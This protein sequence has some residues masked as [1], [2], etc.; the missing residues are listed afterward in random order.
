MV[1]S[2]PQA[3]SFE[4]FVDQYG[5]DTR[6][7]LI[8]GELIDME[9]TG[10]HVREAAPPEQQVSGFIN[11]QLN[12]EIA[13]LRQPY[14]IPMR[15]IIKPLGP[16]SA[17]KPDVIVL[18][19]PALKAEPLWQ[20]EPIIT[21]GTSVKLVVEVV[22]TNWQNDYARKV[23]DYQAFGIQEYWIVDYLGLGGTF[24]IGSPKQPTITICNLQNRRYDMRQFRQGDQLES[25]TF[26][27]LALNAT[28]IFE[29]GSLD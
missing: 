6:Y 17:F 9:P 14:F 26:P 12:L 25:P 15:C 8:D 3:T 7:E 20:R 28:S 13:K 19:R 11:G 22:S 24:F 18:D 29:A 1:Q 10:P 16:A 27:D 2:L 21:L 23:D 5:D 4:E